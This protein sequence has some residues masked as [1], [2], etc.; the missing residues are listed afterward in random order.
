MKAS[1]FFRCASCIDFFGLNAEYMQA[2]GVHVVVSL[3]GIL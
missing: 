2:L 1:A 3:D